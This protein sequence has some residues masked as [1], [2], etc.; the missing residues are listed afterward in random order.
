MVTARREQQ[1]FTRVG[2]ES[3]DPLGHQLGVDDLLRSG[4]VSHRDDVRV[5]GVPG[6]DRGDRTG[7]AIGVGHETV[8]A[9]GLAR[10]E[11]ALE[12]AEHA[13]PRVGRGFGVVRRTRVA[14]EAVLGIGVTDDFGRRPA[15]R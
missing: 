15:R 4:P 8:P 11:M 13:A 10:A 3:L 6:I 2:P 5:V 12:P 7:E 9:V 1:R 14:V